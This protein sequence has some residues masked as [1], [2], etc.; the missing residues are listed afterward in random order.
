MNEKK[1]ARLYAVSNAHLDTQWNWTIKDTIKDCIKDTLEK[2]FELFEKYPSYRM[3]FEGAFHYKL[4]KEYYPEGYEKMKGYVKEGRWTP[5]GSAWDAMDVNVPSSEALMRQ[6]LYGNN[7]F[8]EELGVTAKDIFL[9]DCFGFRPALPSIAAHMG[10]IAFS[11]QKLEWGVGAPRV[12]EDGT[13]IPPEEESE[14]PQMDLG[15]WKGPDGKEIFVSLLSGN[16]T[17][18]FDSHGDERPIN[19]REELLQKLEHNEKVSGVAARNLYFGTGDYGGSCS[20]GSARLLEEAIS[21]KGEGLFD[22]IC[23]TPTDIYN[24][25]TEEEKAALPVYEG[26]L[27]IPHGYGAMTSH[28]AMKRLNRQN[29]QAADAC[30]RASVFAE[31]LAGEPYP[32]ERITEAWKSFLWHQFHDDLT[33]TSI[34]EAYLYSHNDEVLSKN[35]F[36]KE[37]AHSL[38]K[39]SALLDTSKLERPIVLY[40]PCTFERTEEVRIPLNEDDPEKIVVLDGKGEP[41]PCAIGED[42]DGRYLCFAPNLAPLSLTAFDIRRGGGGVSKDG[43]SVCENVL[44]N[45]CLKVTLDTQGN[46]CSIFDKRL[47]N[48]LLS[49]PIREEIFDDNSTVWPSWEYNFDDLQKEPRAD[50]TLEKVELLDRRPVSVGLLVTRRYGA[51]TFQN[52]LTLTVGCPT[53]KVKATVDWQEKNSLLTARFPLTA[54]NETALF[55]GGLGALRGGITNSYPYFIHN[56]HRWA[57]QSDKSGEFGVTLAND[58]K[59]AMMKPDEKSL[60][61]VLIHT[62]KANYS[63]ESGQDFQDFGENLYSWSIT[64]HK[65]DKPCIKEAEALNAPILAEDVQPCAG[66]YPSLSLM[67]IAEE[68]IEVRALKKEEK[69]DRYILRLQECY[70]EAHKSVKVTLPHTPV[71]KAYICNGYEQVEEQI[72]PC[73]SGL[74]LDFEP[75]EVKSLMLVFETPASAECDDLPLILPF[76]DRISLQRGE[77]TE[78]EGVYLPAELMQKE[79]TSCGVRYT[80]GASDEQNVLCCEGQILPLS[81]KKQRV[82]LLLASKTTDKQVEFVAGERKNAFTVRPFNAPVGA[83]PMVVCGSSKLDTSEEIAAFFT[84]TKN[85]DGSVRLYDFAYIFAYTVQ[86][87]GAT[88]LALPNDPD[89]LLFAAT[90][91]DRLSVK[92]RTPLFDGKGGEK[93]LPLRTLTAEGCKNRSG[94]YPSGTTVLLYAPTVSENGLFEGFEGEG[95]TLSRDNYALVTLTN[96]D[97]TVKARYKPLGT[98]IS[99]GKPCSASHFI[100]GREAPEKAVDGKPYTKWCG[101]MSENGLWMEVDLEKEEA[102]SKVLICHAGDMES[103]SWNTADFEIQVKCAPEEHYRTVVSV[104]NNE[105]TTTLHEFEPTTARF[106]R[107]NVLKPAVNSN[108][109]ARIYQLQIFKEE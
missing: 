18:N 89:I 20:E 76:N 106:V 71:L 27:F 102:I 86:T 73:N 57:D 41:L 77:C 34:A 103:P 72:S 52:E 101:R 66:K 13:T 75:Y 1:R 11:T 96:K 40:N 14:L 65:G 78:N 51:S 8:E 94:C 47:N 87:D 79:I 12:K 3:N 24:D 83:R 5:V 29:E 69:G 88:T 25:L 74:C 37:G 30:E 7:F 50:F 43:L 26:G 104:K 2:N 68:G 99:T 63:P 98:N 60:S 10:L 17:Y 64:A 42:V 9:P 97:L 95:I 61:P 15:R 62:P 100:N 48:E 21:R 33:G 80:L 67:Q 59:Y 91:T 16:Y 92:E 105:K 85:A 35:I 38:M 45:D 108:P 58:C 6:V 46:I 39:L 19:Q 49:A 93:R 107:L 53:L 70:G 28:A 22:V 36:R 23:A 31:L 84:H 109:C 54:Q 44:E 82:R 4:M 56:V 90:E 81:G 55:D 32:K